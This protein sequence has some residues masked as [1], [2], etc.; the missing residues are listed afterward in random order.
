MLKLSKIRFTELFLLVSVSLSRDG[1][2]DQL[3]A[4]RTDATVFL[5]RVQFDISV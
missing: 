2:R 3:T 4:L 5:G 1:T